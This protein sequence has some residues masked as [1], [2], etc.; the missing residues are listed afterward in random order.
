MNKV[1]SDLKNNPIKQYPTIGVCGLDCGL[2]TRYYTVGP[3]RCPGCAGP[4]FFEKH[5]SCFFI[6]CAVKQKNLEVCVE[7]SD[8]PCHKFKSEA[9][10][11]QLDE[12]PSY[13]SYRKVLPNFNYIKEYGIKKFIE[14]QKERIRLLEIMRANFDDGRSRSFF[15]RAANLLEITDIKDALDEA[16]Q[17]VETNNVNQN[18][19]KTRAKILRE[20]LLAVAFREGIEL[21]K[22][23]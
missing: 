8:F 9:E 1:I 11:Q 3:S 15:C 5:P 17:K 10:Y 18:D 16:V 22:K 4:G 13:P 20:T 2:C 21:I 19:V 6:T 14:Q 7:C 12:S 23:R